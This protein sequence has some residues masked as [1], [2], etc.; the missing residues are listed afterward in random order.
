ML[1]RVTR[2]NGLAQDVKKQDKQSFGTGGEDTVI[3]SYR[4]SIQKP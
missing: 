3:A 2:K 1:G 4:K